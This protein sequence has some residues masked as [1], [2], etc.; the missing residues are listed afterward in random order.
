MSS[1]P[2]KWF[3][4]TDKKETI[5]KSV[6]E[7]INAESSV[8]SLYEVTENP[9]YQLIIVQLARIIHRNC[10]LNV[11]NMFRLSSRFSPSSIELHDFSL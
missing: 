7:S 5:A 11:Q 4:I 2:Q 10:L 1:K 3:F 9:E 6:F 8:S